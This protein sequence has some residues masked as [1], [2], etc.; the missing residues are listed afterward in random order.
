MTA[1]RVAIVRARPVSVY[2][3]TL[4]VDFSLPEQSRPM[5]RIGQPVTV[6]NRPAA[7]GVVAMEQ[8]KNAAPDGHTIGLVSQGTM[9][10]N[11]FLTRTPRYD[12]QRDVAPVAV[13]ATVTNALVVAKTSP[14]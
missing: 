4:R 7:G 10:F 14:L 12:P 11:H 9:V 6:D 8:L 3:D 5:I 1:I 13:F 2:V